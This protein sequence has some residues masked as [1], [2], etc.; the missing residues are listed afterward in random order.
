M[1]NSDTPAQLRYATYPKASQEVILSGSLVF[2][3]E[4]WTQRRTM[5]KEHSTQ[6]VIDPL[7]YKKFLYN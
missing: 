3:G 5:L 1:T 6:A 4:Y 7:V 2:V